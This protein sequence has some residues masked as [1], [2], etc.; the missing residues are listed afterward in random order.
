MK[1]FN[2]SSNDQS[3]AHTSQT[4]EENPRKSSFLWQS[5]GVFSEVLI[6][7]AIICLLYIVWQMWWT[8]AQSE[9]AQVADRNAVSWVN[10]AQQGKTKIAKPQTDKP[11]VVGKPKIGELLARIYIPRFGSQ[12]E[13]NV[14]E[15]ST[16]EILNRRG[17]GH[18]EGTQMPAELGNVAIA[19]HR[20]GYGQPLIDVD[21]L[22]P[23]D[24]IILRT[25]DYWFVYK[26]TKHV[27]VTPDHVEVISPN[28]D[29]PSA[30]PKKRLITLTTC[31]PKYSTP[32]HR[33]ISYGELDYWAKVSDG[34]PKELSTLDENG[35]VKFIN[36]EQQSFLSHIDSLIPIILVVIGL[37]L[38]VFVA[39]SIAWQWPLR[40][41]VRVGL[42]PKPDASIFAGITHLQPGITPVRWT[43]AAL[44][45]F[46]IILVLF[47]WVF[48]W[49]SATIPF[50][51]S[52]SNYVAI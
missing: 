10:P 12:W 2:L 19:G 25:K 29:D 23:G 52:M 24:P 3:V 4:Q 26:Y 8:G 37:Y 15:G 38:I 48:P 50:L 46:L 14:V 41:M 22:Q 1:H 49:A 5:I 11:P 27:I 43:L 16:M 18:Y 7:T 21:K 34:I 42:K 20:N 40:R 44:V 33:W 9:H 36:D 32:T 51:Q 39:A 13:R 47:Q 28:P 31:E 30:N 6:A 17:L 45:Y 35:N